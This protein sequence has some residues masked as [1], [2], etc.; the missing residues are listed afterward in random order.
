LIENRISVLLLGFL[1]FSLFMFLLLIGVPVLLCSSVA[2]LIYEKKTY[3]VTLLTLTDDGSKAI[4]L[5][6][7][8]NA[9]VEYPKTTHGGS[10]RHSS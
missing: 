1:I 3:N 6:D 10:V 2:R 8:S 5:V 9:I 4:S 7:I